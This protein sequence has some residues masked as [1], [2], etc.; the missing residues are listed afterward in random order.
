LIDS[1]DGSVGFAV[2]FMALNMLASMFAEDEVLSR[3]HLFL[4]GACAGVAMTMIA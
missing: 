1:F 2:A 4:A 3:V